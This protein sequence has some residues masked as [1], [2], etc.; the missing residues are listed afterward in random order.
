M[1]RTKLQLS[2][3]ELVAHEQSLGFQLPESILFIHISTNVKM[4]L[5]CP[6]M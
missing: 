2:V 6:K 1:P 5:T 3:H 4:D